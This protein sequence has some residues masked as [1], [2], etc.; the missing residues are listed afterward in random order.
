M[1]EYTVSLM[2]AK[3]EELGGVSVPLVDVTLRT[4]IGGMHPDEDTCLLDPPPERVVLLQCHGPAPGTEIGHRRRTDQD[5]P[6]AP[7]DDVVQL[8]YRGVEDRQVDHWRREDP[9]FEVEGPM[10]GHPLVER[11]DH[12]C[13]RLRVVR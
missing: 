6:S 7:L 8:A 9:V 13:G 3:R 2:L 11:V 4:I 1:I 5:R 12:H 10:L